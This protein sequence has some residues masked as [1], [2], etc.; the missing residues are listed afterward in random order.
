MIVKKNKKKK[1]E[2]KDKFEKLFEPPYD[3]IFE[4]I[5]SKDKT[6]VIK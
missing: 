4:G 5:F 3:I 6:K 1:T 2:P